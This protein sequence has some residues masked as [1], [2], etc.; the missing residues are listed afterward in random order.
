MLEDAA[1][2]ECNKELRSYGKSLIMGDKAAV[3]QG[4]DMQKVP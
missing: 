1:V 3:D 4:V 2:S